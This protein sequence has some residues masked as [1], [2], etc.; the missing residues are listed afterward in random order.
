RLT[1]TDQGLGIEPERLAKLFSG[2]LKDVG[3]TTGGEDSSG[4]GL[5][6]VKRLVE[7]MRGSVDCTSEPGVGSSFS[8]DLPTVP[9]R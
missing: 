8:I 7:R 1:V 9:E 2:P 3:K 5:V 6:S 4:I